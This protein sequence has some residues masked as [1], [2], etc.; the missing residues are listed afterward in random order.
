MKFTLRHHLPSGKFG[1]PMVIL[2][3]SLAFFLFSRT[4]TF[5]MEGTSALMICLLLKKRSTLRCHK[6]LLHHSPAA[7]ASPVP[8]G[9]NTRSSLRER[10][11]SEAGS[12]GVRS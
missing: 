3:L 7:Y 11:N 6:G 8:S 9:E 2:L 5:P 1:I 10:W 4:E 12:N